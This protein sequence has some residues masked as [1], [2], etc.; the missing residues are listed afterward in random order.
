[1]T[2][3]EIVALLKLAPH[4]EGGFYR[5][6]FR[7]ADSGGGRA[8]STA[9]YYLL[10]QGEESRWHR[11]DASEVWHWYAGS[12]LELLVAE[13]SGIRRVVLGPALNRG[14]YPQAVVPA[15]LW[16]SAKSLGA[17]TLLGCTVAPGFEFSGFEMAPEGWAP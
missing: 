7:D 8:R 11:V 1:M 4:P 14:E 13:H 16:Q 9:I 12:A 2:A 5:E 6:M 3:D 15:R 10:R 17:F